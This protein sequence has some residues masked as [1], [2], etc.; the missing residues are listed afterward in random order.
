[1]V[2]TRQLIKMRF[3]GYDKGK[4]TQGEGGLEAIKPQHRLFVLFLLLQLSTHGENLELSDSLL[5]L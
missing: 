2:E 3:C 4:F 1:M 5:L